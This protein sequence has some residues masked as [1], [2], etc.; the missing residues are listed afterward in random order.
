MQPDLDRIL[1][2]EVPVIV[3]LGERQMTLGEVRSL[4]PGMLIELPNHSDD[5]LCLLVN[6]KVV[7]QGSAVKVGENFG[8]CISHIGAIEDRVEALGPKGSEPA[9]SDADAEAAALAEAMLAGQL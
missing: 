6:N 1:K 3:R 2:I 5:E 7:G 4:M 8:I 9:Q